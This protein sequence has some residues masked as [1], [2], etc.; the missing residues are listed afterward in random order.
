MHANGI[1]STFLRW[2]IKH[3]S[4]KNF[5]L[6]LSVIVGLG[7]GL[8]AVTLKGTVHYIHH[9][10]SG[11]DT[12]S[13]SNYWYV[14]YPLIGLL[15]T[16]LISHFIFK[17]RLGH[18]ISNILFII[19]K[20]SSD[21]KPSMTFSR[22][23]T[24]ALT[25]GFGG[26]VGLEAPIVVT[27]SAIGSNIAKQMHLNYKYRT[28]LLGCGA[29]GAVA[30]IFNSPIAGVIFVI[31]VIV[32]DISIDIFIPL[33]L[34]AVSGATI[35]Q[36]LL[37]EEILF[38]F[39]IIEHFTAGEIPFYLFL[40]I[41]CGLVALYF[42]R[43][44]YYFEGLVHKIKN[45]FVRLLISGSLLGLL[46]AVLPGLYGEGYTTIKELI[47]G[48]GAN[49]VKQT[50]F[51]SDQY[52]NEVVVLLAII[53]ALIL[54]KAVAT[55]L[56]IGSGGSG[57]IFAPSLMIGALSGYLIATVINHTGIGHVSPANFALV[58][59][60]GVFS[61]VLHAPLTGIFLIAEI[62]G[63]YALMLPLMLVSAI[64]YLVISYFEPYSIYTKHL[65]ER[66]DLVIANRDK[67]VLSRMNMSKL[68]EK[69]FKTVHPDAF[70]GDLIDQVKVSRRNIFPVVDSECGLVG[71]ITLDDVRHIMFDSKK[72]NHVIVRTIMLIPKEVIQYNDDMETV[73]AKFESSA[74]WNLPVVNGEEY[75]GF[76]SKSSIFSVY[77]QS[78]KTHQK[79]SSLD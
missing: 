28:L 40:G 36:V 64:S 74:K 77:R 72:Q 34:A 32:V 79:H 19:N 24:S 59:M 67:M 11:N 15:V 13:F 10:L 55:A 21:I 4:N 52:Y 3:V 5:V 44:Q 18:G 70:L 60:C 53:T 57:G 25:V 56:T 35:S 75:I 22:M 48:E 69:D 63:G 78:L 58:G 49:I 2:R 73:M 46:V 12:L 42:T 27:G 51:L 38:K 39:D 71:I 47:S 54:V 1:V 43:I 76:I 33:L 7:A 62:T 65:V 26:S 37:G 61:G 16:F 17:E 41:S 9:F 30:G 14:T 20:G 29:A 8:A 45:D 66:G 23:I 68:I 6:I 50:L 31:E